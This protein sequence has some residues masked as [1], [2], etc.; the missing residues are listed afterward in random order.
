MVSDEL[1]RS[2][3]GCIELASKQCTRSTVSGP[4]CRWG[5]QATDRR[6]LQGT[7]YVRKET[8]L[9]DK[10]SRTAILKGECSN[11]KGKDQHRHIHFVGGIARQAAAYPP[12]LVRAVLKVL[13]EEL[14]DRGRPNSHEATSSGRVPEECLRSPPFWR[15]TIGSWMMSTEAFCQRTEEVKKA[16]SLEMGVH[17]VVKRSETTA[18]GITFRVAMRLLCSLWSMN[19]FSSHEKR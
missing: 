4:M 10:P 1:E 13:K 2:E 14:A 9:D 12:R 17:R 16:R 18:K 19:R 11:R 8:G 5:M 15:T 6:G 3:S 7:S